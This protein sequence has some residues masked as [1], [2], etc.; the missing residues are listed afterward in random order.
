MISSNAPHGLETLIARY[1]YTRPGKYH[2]YP[3]T[4]QTE[5]KTK[6]NI[7]RH[8]RSSSRFHHEQRACAMYTIIGATTK[9]IPISRYMPPIFTLYVHK[10]PSMILVMLSQE[11][12][13][14][15]QMISAAQLKRSQTWHIIIQKT[16]VGV[17]YVTSRKRGMGKL[18]SVHAVV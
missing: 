1:T 4:L 6:Q 11:I 2:Q 8:V 9:I 3:R 7:T 10:V 15:R 13:T 16:W 5:P 18:E 12:T 17:A 14:Q